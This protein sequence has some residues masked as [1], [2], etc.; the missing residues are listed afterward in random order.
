MRDAFWK[1]DDA[2]VK[3][4][5]TGVMVEYQHEP[6]AWVLEIPK[7]NNFVVP[8]HFKEAQHYYKQVLKKDEEWMQ[9]H[10]GGHVAII[11]NQVVAY[12]K[13]FSQL[14]PNVRRVYGY[15]PLFMPEVISGEEVVH[16]GPHIGH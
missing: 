10:L 7:E 16:I 15:G 5:L 1:M 13:N 11:G 8:P 14:S 12:E 9:Q 6:P 4:K 3:A 2:I